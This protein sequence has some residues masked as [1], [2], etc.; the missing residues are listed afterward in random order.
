MGDGGKEQLTCLPRHDAKGHGGGPRTCTNT[1]A[2]NTSSTLVA[3][4]LY[5]EVTAERKSGWS[6]SCAHTNRA[7][8]RA[9]THGKFC[10][11][12]APWHTP[13]L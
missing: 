7:R 1:W 3:Y 10:R 11:T 4:V 8:A 13:E 5:A 6:P 9:S 12:K 2:K